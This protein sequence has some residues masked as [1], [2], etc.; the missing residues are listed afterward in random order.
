VTINGYFIE[1]M[2]NAVKLFIV[3]VSRGLILFYH[4]SS[5]D[6]NPLSEMIMSLVSEADLHVVRVVLLFCSVVLF[7][8]VVLLYSV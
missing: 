7:C 5:N 3:S 8:V 4:V 1:V 6:V 2:T